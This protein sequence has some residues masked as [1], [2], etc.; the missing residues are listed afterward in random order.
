MA[1]GIHDT[2]KAAVFTTF[3]YI[4][5]LPFVAS[6]VFISAQI[7]SMHIRAARCG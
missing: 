2:T 5:T 4:Y 3:V 6:Y 1:Y 7:E